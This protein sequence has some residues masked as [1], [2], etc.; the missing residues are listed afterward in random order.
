LI[1]DPKERDLLPQGCAGQQPVEL[2]DAIAGKRFAGGEI[3]RAR[4]DQTVNVERIGGGRTVN[5]AI[6]DL[7]GNPESD[8]DHS[9]EQ[10][11]ETSKQESLGKTQPAHGFCSRRMDRVMTVAFAR[12]EYPTNLT[13]PL[14][15]LSL[16]SNTPKVAQT[17][18]TFARSSKRE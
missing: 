15:D 14:C 5:D 17:F 3:L 9:D 12:S 1:P 7:I 11:D 13:N 16:T 8:A 6:A 4:R 18:P 10:N 2:I